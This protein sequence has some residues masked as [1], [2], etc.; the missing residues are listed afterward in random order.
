MVVRK[1]AATFG[2][3]IVIA[4]WTKEWLP[5]MDVGLVA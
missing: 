3:A 1:Q 2:R 4:C 5:G